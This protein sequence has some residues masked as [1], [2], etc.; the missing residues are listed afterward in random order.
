MYVKYVLQTKQVHNDKLP[1]TIPT[2]NTRKYNE[3]A[4]TEMANP[5]AATIPPVIPHLHGPNFVTI[6][7][8]IDPEMVNFKLIISVNN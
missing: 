2:D 3:V 7:P 4:K 1:V 5:A 8:L 6:I